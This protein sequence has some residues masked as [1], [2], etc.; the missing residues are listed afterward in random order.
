MEP[1]GGVRISVMM[2]FL[3]LFTLF[4]NQKRNKQTIKTSQIFFYSFVPSFLPRHTHKYH[5]RAF[6][7]KSHGIKHTVA[8][9]EKK[10][11]SKHHAFAAWHGHL[12]ENLFATVVGEQVGKRDT[13]IIG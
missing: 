1:E 3:S 5:S 13:H 12:R 7:D 6:I 4:L 9:G 8:C 2:M 11:N 10:Q